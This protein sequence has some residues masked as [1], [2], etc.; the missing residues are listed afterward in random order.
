VVT[1]LDSDEQSFL[2]GAQWEINPNM[3]ST[4]KIGYVEKNFDDSARKDWNGLGWSLDL[5]MQPR[6]QDTIIV[7]T[8]QSPEE[9]TLQGDFI[10]R[11]L[12]NFI[13]DL[14]ELLGLMMQGKLRPHISARYPLAEGRTA[15]NDLMNRKATGKVVIT[16]GAQGDA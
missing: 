2:V 13:R 16:S 12:P 8:T 9:T 6:D 7:V 14:T 11:E 10:R 15:L 1:E 4:A 5:W 3:T